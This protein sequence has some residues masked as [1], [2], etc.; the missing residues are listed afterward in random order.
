M[1]SLIGNKPNQVPTNG[2][3]G[4]L[5][6]Q[7]ANAVNITGGVITLDKVLTVTDGPIANIQPVPFAGTMLHLAGQT[8]GGTGRR[9]VMDAYQA[10]GPVIMGRQSNGTSTARVATGAGNAL[11]FLNSLGSVDNAGTVAFS[12]NFGAYQRFAAAENFTPTAQGTYIDWTVNPIGSV[13][14]LT[15]LNLTS[16]ALTMS[17]KMSATQFTNAANTGYAKLIPSTAHS[18]KVVVFGSSVAFGTG[19]TSNQGWAYMLGQA[20]TSQGWTYTNASVGGNNTVDLI[21]RFY[22]DLVPLQPDV[23]IIGLSLANEGILGTNKQAIFNQYINN[24]YKLVDMCRQQGFKV[25]VTGTY[26]NNSYTSVEYNYIKQADKFLQTS[27]IPYINFLGAIDDGTG[28]WRTGMFADDGHPNDVGHTALYRAIPLSLF[29]RL[30]F[31]EQNYSFNYPPASR[32]VMTSDGTT[33]NPI[34]YVVGSEPFGSW[35][36]ILNARMINSSVPIGVALTSIYDGT[37]ALPLRLRAPFGVWEVATGNTLV[38]SSV[39]PTDLL[40]HQLAVSYDYFSDTVKLYVDG[41]YYGAASTSGFGANPTQFIFL[42]RPDSGGVNANGFAIANLAIYKTALNADQIAECN[43][44]FYPKAG[45]QVFA[46]CVD[47][48]ITAGNSLLNLA[49]S[50]ANLII[51]TPNLSRA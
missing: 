21:N 43:R 51:N 41:V 4:T 3:L 12:T 40:D 25:I 30:S 46:P 44:G 37:Q 20:L 47:N 33:L 17:G 2:D 13:T 32:I 19:A 15:V 27:Q 14:N 6:F 45:L 35:T 36:M 39:A 42:G 34:N 22:T 29:D 11:L 49:P 18:K 28:K 10:N 23:V 5:A 26:P 9:F 38:S 1:P 8:E 7:D 16:T 48:A 24:M 31:V 50:N